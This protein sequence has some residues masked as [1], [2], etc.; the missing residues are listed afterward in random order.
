MQEPAFSGVGAVA[1]DWFELRSHLP[2]P[3][4]DGGCGV[5]PVNAF[6]LRGREPMLLDTGLAALRTPFM[7]ALEGLLPLKELRW[8]WISHMDA[9]HVGNLP[10]VLERAPEARV[11]TNFLGMGKMALAG[12]PTDRVHLLEPGGWLTLGDREIVPVRPPYYD[13]P[14]SIG[15]FD[16]ATR[17]LFAVDAFGALL[18]APVTEAAAIPDAALRAGIANWSAIDAPWL[19]GMGEDYLLRA[20]DRIE[21]LS[22]SVV[23]SGHLPA[24]RGMTGALLSHLAAA[25]AQLSADARAA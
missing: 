15:C 1:P 8:I 14:E 10:A 9:D 6:L 21:R 19:A 11:V 13:A 18:D 20:F 17:T 7:A 12:L 22:P 16:T 3:S 2:V 23:L 24:A 4:P 5:L 25:C